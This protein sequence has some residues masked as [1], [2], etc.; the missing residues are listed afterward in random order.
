MSSGDAKMLDPPF[1][2]FQI[3]T[4]RALTIESG[5]GELPSSPDAPMGDVCE[6]IRH[7]SLMGAR[8]NSGVILSQILR[9]LA[10]TFAPLERVGAHSL[11]VV[12]LLKQGEMVG[13]IATYRTVWQPFADNQIALVGTFADQ[14]VIAIENARLFEEV[15]ARNREIAEALEQQTATGEILRVISSSP[16]DVQ[17]VFDTIVE[18]AV[19]LCNGLFS[20]LFR[21]DGELITQV[22]QHN[23]TPESLEYVRRLY[24]ARPSREHGSA[25]AI[26]ERAIVHIPDVEADPEYVHRD[27]TR[28]VGLRSGLFVPMMKDG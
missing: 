18:S 27:M 2:A 7:G 5:V 6:A 16:T 24:P 19:R 13:A 17:P 10:D 9:G 20:A 28:A 14:A 11:L 8:G 22:A 12:P 3:G 1:S 25:R 4:I 26:L 21:Y 15:E 23:F